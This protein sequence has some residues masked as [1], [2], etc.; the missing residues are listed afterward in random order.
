MIVLVSLA[1][2]GHARRLQKSDEREEHQDLQKN[3]AAA[4]RNSPRSI[5]GLKTNL[6]S[7]ASAASDAFARLLVAH[8]PAA[9][10]SSL[11]GGCSG[12][13]WP[14]FH[15]SSSASLGELAGRTATGRALDHQ[16]WYSTD[17]LHARRARAVHFC[18]IRSGAG[19]GSSSDG[20]LSR[21]R[22]SLR[23]SRRRLTRLLPKKKPSLAYILFML[24]A[25]RFITL[26][27]NAR[28]VPRPVEMTFAR[29]MQEVVGSP[30]AFGDMRISKSQISFLFDGERAFTRIVP[31]PVEVIALLQKSGVDFSAVAPSAASKLLPLLFPCLWLAVSWRM[32]SQI[33][34]KTK[35][36]GK[37]D[38]S[39]RL[40]TSDLTFGD[41]AGIDTAKDEVQEIVTMLKE[42]QRFK[43]AG[44]RLPSGVLMCGPPGTGKTLLARVMAAQAGVPFFYC[45]GSDFVELFV[46]RGAARMRA[47][48]K[49]AQ[50][51]APCLIFVDELDA[52]G[53]QRAL[54][55]GGS[56][57]AEQT[58]N[59][60]LA[61]MDGY[62]SSNNGVI[63]LAATNRYE[64]LD[65]ALTR[66]GRFDRVVRI[67]LP[68]ET[69]RTA[70]LAVHTRKLRLAEDVD[71]KLV[72]KAI[73]SYSGAEIAALCNEAA[74]RAVR[75][76][77]EL[78][79]QADFL[80]AANTFNMGRGRLPSVD[81]LL[82]PAW[83]QNAQGGSNSKGN[84]T[85]DAPKSS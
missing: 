7:T 61:C 15:S 60:M 49:E 62:D 19:K 45:S 11:S 67:G 58:L 56:D 74:I 6:Q 54:R 75:R 84:G 78:I 2:A 34:G 64:I 79:N 36:I 30:A 81:N 68:D 77:S 12:S 73:P 38:S 66:P 23:S 63:V 40:A 1:C 20:F 29:F 35:N 57:E 25:I 51:A 17:L 10:F 31:A 5:S 3:D 76:S 22:Q 59:Q 4:A 69:G 70:I 18:A 24:L 41:V 46:G 48:F 37:K 52:L 8:D 65:P 85:P 47:L 82:N 39:F 27:M 13:N 80:N 55:I 72:A 71:L 43:A 50:E 53:K 14:S 28:D 42:P 16:A 33:G 21:L 9:S 26:L 44:A 32:M 83:W